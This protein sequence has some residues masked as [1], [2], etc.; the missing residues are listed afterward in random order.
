LVLSEAFFR[1]NIIS[2]E[3]VTTILSNSVVGKGKERDER[4]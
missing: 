3:P 1:E 2:G 4:L